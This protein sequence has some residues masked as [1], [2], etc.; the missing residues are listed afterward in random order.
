MSI[1]CIPFTETLESSMVGVKCP[2]SKTGIESGPGDANWIV[3]FFTFMTI[4][5]L[6]MKHGFLCYHFGLLTDF[7]NWPYNS[8]IGL[9]IHTYH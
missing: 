9:R 6:K 3:P 8:T 2:L 7:I 5:P 4:P 1:D